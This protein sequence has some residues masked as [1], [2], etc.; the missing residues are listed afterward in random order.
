MNAYEAYVSTVAALGMMQKLHKHNT[1][2]EGAKS[3]QQMV[4]SWFSEAKSNARQRHTMSTM[5]EGDGGS[6]AIIQ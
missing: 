3:I 5:A 6:L 4:A 2:G 1:G